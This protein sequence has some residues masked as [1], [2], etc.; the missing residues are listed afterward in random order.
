MG[1]DL[2]CLAYSPEKALAAID[3]IQASKRLSQ[4]VQEVETVHLIMV[5]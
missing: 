2:R 5:R 4:L 1:G 3:A